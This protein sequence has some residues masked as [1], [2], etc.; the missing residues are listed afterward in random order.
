MPEAILGRIEVHRHRRPESSHRAVAAFS[1]QPG[2]SLS[3]EANVSCRPTVKWWQPIRVSPCHLLVPKS[4]TNW[5]SSCFGRTWSAAVPCPFPRPSQS[6]D[7]R[8]ARALFSTTGCDHQLR[9]QSPCQAPI[10]GSSSSNCWPHRLR[11]S[12][13]CNWPPSDWP[14]RKPSILWSSR[15]P[16]F[17]TDFDRAH[18]LRPLLPVYP[19][20][21]RFAIVFPGLCTCLRVDVE[22]NAV[23][24][25]IRSVIFSWVCC[26]VL[27]FILNSKDFLLPSRFD[28]LG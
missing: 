21:I 9:P 7:R 20:W 14:T 26:R 5:K 28:D 16:T 10:I 11:Y 8:Q 2:D 12:L 27:R 1:P 13:S 18:S 15:W 24:P 22:C 23:E 17:A 4:T 19:N 3:Q 25:A 6:A